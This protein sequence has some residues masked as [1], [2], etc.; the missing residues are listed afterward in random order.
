MANQISM[1]PSQMD[2]CARKAKTTGELVEREVI[3]NMD[4]LLKQLKDSWK[5]DAYGGYEA[6]YTTIRKSL[7]N[8]KDLLDE[9]HDNLVASKKIIEE[10]DKNIAAQFKKGGK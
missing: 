6:R 10:T 8:A 3:K 9:I 4:N 5:G 7:V 2:A 1:T